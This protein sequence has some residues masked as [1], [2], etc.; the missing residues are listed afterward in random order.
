MHRNRFFLIVTKLKS[1]LTV[2][3]Q[4]FAA[5]FLQIA[6]PSTA[7]CSVASPRVEFSSEKISLCKCKE[8][9]TIVD[10]SAARKAFSQAVAFF[11]FC[12]GWQFIPLLLLLERSLSN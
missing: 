12:I 7:R 5:C 6:V 9:Q 1:S 8:H 10:K 4:V 2:D 11:F 3:R